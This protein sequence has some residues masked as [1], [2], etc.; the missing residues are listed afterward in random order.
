MAIQCSLYQKK[1]ARQKS[2]S[3]NQTI[4]MTSTQRALTSLGLL[5]GSS[6]YTHGKHNT[7][8]ATPPSP[9]GVEGLTDHMEQRGDNI[10]DSLNK[11]TY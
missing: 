7:A 5:P 1:F 2:L 11:L 9:N 4:S 10:A 3:F 6:T 8:I